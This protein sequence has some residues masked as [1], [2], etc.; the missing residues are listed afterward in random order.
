MSIIFI[1]SVTIYPRTSEL[2]LK[3]FYLYYQNSFI[4]KRHGI[5]K[6]FNFKLVRL[7]GS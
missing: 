2:V 4:D 5:D 3:P 6:S 1:S 7:I